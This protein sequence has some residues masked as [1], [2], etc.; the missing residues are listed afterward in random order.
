[1]RT[2]LLPLLLLVACV[3][4]A[5]V[6]A[7]VDAA[8]AQ[9]P[10]DE[11]IPSD[12]EVRMGTLDNGLRWYVEENHEPQ[13][14][15]EL[16][17]V[18]KA[19]SV[20]EDDDQL[21]LAHFLEHMAFNGSEHFEHNE[22][23]AYMESIGMDFGAE[24]NAY[25]GFDQTVYMLTV[26]TDDPTLLDQ[27][28]LVL[29][30]QGGGLLLDA[31]EVDKERGVVHEEW[32]TRRGAQGRIT[33]QMVLSTFQ[34][35][36]YAQRL[37]IG[38]EESILHFD[39]AALRRFYEEW[40]RPDLMAVI[41]VGDFQAQEVIELIEAR[42]A[43]MANPDQPRPRP[44]VEI[45]ARQEPVITVITDPEIPRTMVELADQYDELYGQTYG[46]YREH[47]VQ[48]LLFWVINERLGTLA[49]QPDPPF[50]G[51]GTGPSRLN[52]TEVSTILGA[53]CREEGVPRAVE[54]L[55]TEVQ[56][57]QRH[58]VTQAELERA[59]MGVLAGY[60]SYAR[61]AEKTPSSKHAEELIRVF[62]T[63]ETMPGIE[64][65]VEMANTWVPRITKAEVDAMAAEW[66]G[67]GS[68]VV[69]V[70]MPEKE[71]LE[72]PAPEQL[73]VLL[74]EVEARD[75]TA[76]AEESV[77]QPLLEPLPPEGATVVQR[78]EV[79]ELGVTTWTLSNGVEIWLKPTDFKDDEIRLVATSAGG[80]SLVPDSDYVIARSAPSIRANSGLGA[81]DPPTLGKLLT[82]QR[83]TT[84]TSVG[85][86]DE[87][88][89]ASCPPD[90]LETMLQLLTLQ[91]TQPRFTEEGLALYR[92]SKEESLR[93]RLSDP[94]TVFGDAYDQL[95]WGDH[96]RNQPW[97][98]DTLDQLDLARS[99]AFYRDRF[100]NAADFHWVMV[101]NLDLEA[102]E[103]LIVRYLGALPASEQREEA[104]DD[105]MVRLPGRHEDVVRAGI[106]PKA[107]VKMTWH[108]P[109]ES[110][111]LHRNR[112]QALEDILD[113]R[114][115]DAI[116]EDKGGTY[117]VSVS[118][119]TWEQPEGGYRLSISF[120]CDPERVD[121]LVAAT[122]AEV[123]RIRT[124]PV[125]DEEIVI[126][127]EK[128]RRDREESVRSNGFWAGGMAGALE[129]GEDPREL[130]TWDARN[131][132]LS[133]VEVHEMAAQVF[134]EEAGFVQLVLL[135][136]ESEE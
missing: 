81:F 104:G 80:R 87:G 100:A 82:G 20:L 98:V 27:G 50:L 118:S 109:F 67:R 51:A 78:G 79:P 52:A 75:V 90:E 4:T 93:N 101:G 117:G 29:R 30:D 71:G 74:A 73:Q 17:L 120:R 97:T 72:P 32:R 18:V 129:R 133:A 12:P 14:R 99:E 48:Q 9:F 15:A 33:D 57:A 21:G 11:V 26:P 19:G 135:P 8:T 134:S 131:D 123:E 55:W 63:D 86:F 2:S 77:D 41:A 35:S 13:Q 34:G 59:R 6:Q 136:E 23:V 111:W 7:P 102:M 130:M 3:H 122:L 56:R 53:G 92:Q 84:G 69:Q 106:D 46:D 58:G 114:L 121:E 49:R 128:N 38:T 43:D 25:T 127:Q 39:P 108:G 60:E 31:E 24:V 45:P 42:F 16:R 66:M 47:L 132:S 125:S 40:Y 5:P 112:I 64:A 91:L 107:R 37:P 103:P 76:L 62:T 115:R 95:M 116:R 110:T 89:R 96:P 126:E 94:D 65:E 10:M 54:A 70:I 22:L 113:V 28:L 36:L 85:R 88:L 124:E 119:G 83:A 61:E 68:L 1:M 44:Q 105:G